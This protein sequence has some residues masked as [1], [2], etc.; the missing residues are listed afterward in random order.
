MG[1][2]DNNGRIELVALEHVVAQL[3]INPSVILE[4]GSHNGEDA[5]RLQKRFDVEPSQ[6]HVV[7]AH[8]TFYKDI[9]DKYPEYSVYNFAANNVSGTVSFNA[10]LDFDDGRSSVL[11]R[12]I[13]NADNF[14]VVECES[15]RLDSF[16]EDQGIESIDIFKLDVEGL[17]Y[18]VLEGMGDLISKVKCIQVETEYNQMWNDQKVA[19]DTYDYLKSKDFVLVWRNNVANLQDDS[20]WVRRDLLPSAQ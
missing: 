20:I 17:S 18:E 5:E 4:V 13:Y 16:I 10:A 7:E 6:V 12:D 8:P 11:Q 1:S 3:S 9:V 14:E 2:A 15:K 19:Q